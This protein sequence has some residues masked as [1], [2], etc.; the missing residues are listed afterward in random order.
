MFALGVN[1]K[2]GL[3]IIVLGGLLSSS[4][5]F[6]DLQALGNGFSCDGGTLLKGTK[7]IKYSKAKSTL[8]KTLAKLK[9]Q[10]G[11][12]PKKK[13]AAIKAKIDALKQS[14]LQITA[15]IKGTLNPN[16][17][18]PIFTQ[19]SSGNGTYTGKYHGSVFGFALDGDMTMSFV[20]TGTILNANLSLGAP[21]GPTVDNK[22]LGFEGDVAGIGFPAKFFL[23]PTFLGDVTLSIGQDGH[24]TITNSNSPNAT[25][26]FDGHF[27]NPT[28]SGSLS[29]SYNG[30]PFQ[31]TFSLT[32]Q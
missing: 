8:A 1:M 4:V 10:L 13:R 3:K 15:C 17:A 24:V 7:S 12:A 16:Q 20:L 11:T 2:A 9:A 31:G 22:P 28:I 32:H 6:A 14:R 25:V 18:D 21:L 23:S 5:A 30:F 29:G 26:N 19:L 27:T